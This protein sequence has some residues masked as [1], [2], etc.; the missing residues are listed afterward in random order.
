[1][2][3]LYFAIFCLARC[4]LSAAYRRQAGQFL[5]RS[6]PARLAPARL[7][8]LLRFRL[9]LASARPHHLHGASRHCLLLHRFLDQFLCT[10]LNYVICTS[11][12][13]YPGFHACCDVSSRSFLTAT[14]GQ[15]RRTAPS[16]ACLSLQ[17]NYFSGFPCCSNTF[18][19]LWTL[20]ILSSA[21][22]KHC[23]SPAPHRLR[24]LSRLQNYPKNN[25]SPL[26]HYYLNLK[27]TARRRS[28]HLSQSPILLT[29]IIGKLR[30]APPRRC[31]CRAFL[32]SGF[33]CG[34]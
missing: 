30:A 23:R 10:S 19:P 29:C 7:A 31:S 8:R 21:P 12:I 4:C 11:L 5:A 2:R 1:M 17:R 33:C 25:S 3:G 15:P 14:S 34:R 20:T 24:S 6:T 22:P 32:Q 18:S 26:V 13:A 27:V 9:V 16:F 28:H